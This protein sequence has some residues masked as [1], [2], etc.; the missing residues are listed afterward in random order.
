M[1]TNGDADDIDWPPGT[2]G[3]AGGNSIVDERALLLAGTCALRAST[4]V[5]P[6]CAMAPAGTSTHRIAI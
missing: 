5:C 4:G 6:C 3:M 1:R 2:V